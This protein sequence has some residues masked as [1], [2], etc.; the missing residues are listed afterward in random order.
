MAC[1]LSCFVK[2][3][4]FLFSA[5]TPVCIMCAWEDL[6]ITSCAINISDDGEGGLSDTHQNTSATSLGCSH[7]FALMSKKNLSSAAYLLRVFHVES[8]S[9]A[10]SPTPENF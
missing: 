4:P 3:H 2:T 9:S 5:L 1:C 6:V 10:E 7:P 8:S